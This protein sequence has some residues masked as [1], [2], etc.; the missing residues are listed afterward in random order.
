MTARLAM[1]TLCTRT[2]QSEND[3]DEKRQGNHD[4]GNEMETIQLRPTT[5]LNTTVKPDRVVPILSD[6]VRGAWLLLLGSLR[7]I[8]GRLSQRHPHQN[9]HRDSVTELEHSVPGRHQLTLVSCFLSP[10]VRRGRPNRQ[11]AAVSFECGGLLG[12]LT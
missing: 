11:W 3:D 4:K 5:Q 6:K 10:A 2:T 9:Q 7:R 1:S 12:L 8:L